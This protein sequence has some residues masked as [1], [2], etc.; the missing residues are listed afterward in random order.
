MMALT[1]EH[2]DK[3]L[4]GRQN[5]KARGTLT[6]TV[7]TE[8]GIDLTI[9]NYTRSLAIKVFCTECMGWEG[10]VQKCTSPKCALFPFRKNTKLTQTGGSECLGDE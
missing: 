5:A 4:L 8:S 7:R 2:K 9:D 3:L 10:N 6:H 1:Q